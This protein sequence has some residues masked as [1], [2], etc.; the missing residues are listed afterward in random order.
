MSQSEKIIDKIKKCLALAKSSNAHEAA[1]ALRQA[2]SLMKKHNISGL[3]IDAAQA[4]EKNAN[5]S[6]KARPSNWESFLANTTA[7]AFGCHCL[8][9]TTAWRW[10]DQPAQWKFIGTS[11]APGL[12]SYAFD[13]LLRQLKRDRSHYIKTALKRCKRA[14][15]T[16]RADEYCTSWVHAVHKTIENFAPSKAQESAI[17]A[18]MQKHYPS[19]S[20]LE[21]RNRKTKGNSGSSFKD[22][23]AGHKDGANAELNHGVNQ[24]K[25]NRLGS[26]L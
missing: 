6:V 4:N 10:E 12:S 2:Q 9:T 21:P 3:D 11:L 15:K 16:A 22:S 1:I 26:D 23:L 25:S 13:V 8:F 19:V 7:K 17:T 5:A 14:N 20:E 18:Y 24:N